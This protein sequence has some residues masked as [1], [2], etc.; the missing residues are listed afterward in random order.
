MPVPLVPRQFDFECGFRER[1]PIQKLAPE[2][3]HGFRQRTTAQ[4]L[5]RRSKHL[6]VSAQ[7]LR[8]LLS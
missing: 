8:M 3:R 5:R 2:P 4:Y 1:K 7:A 6:R